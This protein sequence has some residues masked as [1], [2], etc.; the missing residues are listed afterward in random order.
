L[1][2]KSKSTNLKVAI[3]GNIGSGKSTFAKF[4]QGFGY[5]VVSSDDISKEILAHDSSARTKII[6]SFGAQSF[7]GNEINTKFIADKVF[8]DPKNLKKIN[9]I[10]HPL[11]QKKIDKISDELL[12]S[13]KMVFVEAALI[14]EAKME[15]MFDFIVL[16][17]SD[18]DIRMKRYLTSRKSSEEDFLKREK[19]QSPQELKQKKADFIFSNN[20][21]TAELKS[22]AIL[23]LKV[24]E[25]FIN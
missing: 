10:L 23:L 25:G 16:I 12:K 7:R 8:S 3:T 21:S 22:K 13:S 19:N 20:G 18:K 11:V 17:V 1:N 24:L 9:S 5:P 2:K 6:K 4:I 14:Y 15:K